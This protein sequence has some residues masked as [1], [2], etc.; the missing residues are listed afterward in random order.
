MSRLPLPPRGARATQTVCQYCT[1]GCGYTAWTWPLGHDGTPASNALGDF[2]GPQAPLTGVPYTASMHTVVLRDGVP[3]NLAIVPAEGSPVNVGRDHSSR[4]AT[5]ASAM[6]ASDGPTRER[7]KWPLLR[8]HDELV[9]VTWE[10][11]IA[12]AAGV[13]AGVKA[14]DGADAI[15]AKAFDHGG[16][17]GGFENNFGVGKLL[18]ETIGTSSVAI[19]NRPAYNSEVWG[20]RDRGV[21]ELHVTAEDGHLCDTLV[22]WGANPFETAT[23]LYLE[24][25]LPN[26]KG[27][28]VA[29][30]RAAFGAD[31]PFPAARLVVVDPRATSSLAIPASIAPD[32]VLHLRPTPGTDVVLADAIARIVWE[33]GWA[34]TAFLAGRSDAES[35]GVYQRGSLQLDQP[36]K[37]VLKRA[38][39]LTGVSRA[40]M[41]KAAEWM[42]RPKSPS[43]RTRTLTFYE[44]GVIW[45]YRNYDTVAAVV[46]LAALGGNLGRPGTGCARQGGHQEGYVRPPYPGSRPPRNIDQHLI[47]GGGKVYWVMGTNPFRSTPRAQE[48][49]EVVTRRTRA[50]TAASDAGVTPEERV[51]AVLDGLRETEG[52]FLIVSELYLTHTAE[53]AHLVLPAAGWGESPITSINCASRLL[54]L[55]DA[56]MDPPGVARPDWWICEAVAEGID[57]RSW[58]WETAE[59]AFLAGGATF[60]DNAVDAAG[61]ESLPAECYRGV[62]YAFLRQRGQQGIQTP[63]RREGER[64]VG[65]VRR[66]AERFGSEDGRF[67]WHAS[68]PWSG[69][70]KAI[71][72]DLAEGSPHP[73]WLTT[74][75]NPHL[76]QT[77][78]HD[79]L[80]PTKVAQVPLPY[81]EIH[82]DDAERLGV[83]AL[84]RVELYNDVGRVVVQA[85]LTRSVAPGQLFALQYHWAGTAN[86]LITSWTDPKTTIPWY[87]GARVGV[88]R[89]GGPGPGQSASPLDASVV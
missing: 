38:E 21:H 62:D 28:T 12:I 55:Y 34:D 80:L 72:A 88:R 4:G 43:H 1:V 20:S 36:A 22:L 26:L 45:G 60:P 7:L 6:F 83:A 53:A 31:E 89:V 24:H 68:D 81:V 40:D 37:K 15:C 44:K 14:S 16:G 64:L 33:K 47:D 39:E 35:F 10:E 11:A 59:D 32:R 57:G 27:D 42:A 63:V 9:P 78:Y 61:A 77:G 65:T 79:R 2:S 46:Q 29:E 13:I 3:H 41:A 51:A 84:D 85:R 18:F 54:R 74:G 5:N 56:F 75:R 8:V 87:K 48:L 69:W 86:A 23:V 67:H 70:P 82:P 25:L 76:W 52:L 50:L 66:Y 58:G 49:R 19:H 30:K 73:F 17:G 71:E